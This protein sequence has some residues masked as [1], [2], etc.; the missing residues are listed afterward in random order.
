LLR[1]NQIN[2]A[3]TFNSLC[4][5][6]ITNQVVSGPQNVQSNFG[7]VKSDRGPREIQYQIK[8]EF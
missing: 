3:T 4:P 8:F 6:G 1:Q 5:N 2:D 7:T